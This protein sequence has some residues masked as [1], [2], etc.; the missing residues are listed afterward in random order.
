MQVAQLLCLKLTQKTDS[1]EQWR[2][3]ALE[4]GVLHACLCGLQSE[5]QSIA[6]SCA[7]NIFPLQIQ[8]HKETEMGLDGLF[9]SRSWSPRQQT[10]AANRTHIAYSCTCVEA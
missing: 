5:D 10:A 9:I 2:K 3:Q 8:P 1:A 6:E 4:S 7:G